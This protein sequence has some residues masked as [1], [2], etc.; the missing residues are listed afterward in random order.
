MKKIKRVTI[1][2]NSD[3]DLNFRKIASSKMM[4]K[5]G[6]YSEAIQEAMMLWI[7]N[8]ESN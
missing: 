3:V 5:T 8:E 4:F 1:A 7:E 2:V 6:W